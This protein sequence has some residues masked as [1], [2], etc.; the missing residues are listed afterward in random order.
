MK[1]ADGQDGPLP[2]RFEFAHQL[3]TA[4]RVLVPREAL[5]QV[6]IPRCLAPHQ[7]YGNRGQH[8]ALADERKSAVLNLFETSLLFKVLFDRV[9]SRR[10]RKLDEEH[11]DSFHLLPNSV[12]PPQQLPV[13]PVLL[14]R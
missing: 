1:I 12:P 2:N 4:W 14:F 13:R 3:R 5:E 9:H 11:D 10:A 8:L 7:I 6:A